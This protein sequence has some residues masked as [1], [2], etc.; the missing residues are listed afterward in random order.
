MK[1]QGSRSSPW[2][3]HFGLASAVAGVL[4]FSGVAQAED[5]AACHKAPAP[6][7]KAAA[8]AKVRVISIPLQE[9][10]ADDNEGMNAVRAFI[11]PETGQLRAP[12]AEEQAALGR[13]I[14]GTSGIRAEAAREATVSATGNMI[15]DIGEA[16]MQDVVV[17][18]GA[19]GKLT[20]VCSPRS[21]T[22]LALTRPLAPNKNEAPKE[23]K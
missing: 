23:E 7:A 5:G 12:T 8:L 4:A 14:A 11:D 22:P 17:R 19:D 15:F 2:V 3:L 20:F 16:G 21:Q 6:S 9:C 10:P 1:C 18:T 13:A